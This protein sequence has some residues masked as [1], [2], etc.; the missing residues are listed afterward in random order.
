MKNVTTQILRAVFK[1]ERERERERKRERER[2]RERKKEREG[3]K[4]REREREHFKTGKRTELFFN[5]YNKLNNH[6]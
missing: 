6:L 3:E 1:R 2:E 4:E 5:K